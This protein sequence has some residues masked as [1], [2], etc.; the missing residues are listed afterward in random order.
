MESTR[1][2]I[3][4]DFAVAIAA[5]N[6]VNT[7]DAIEIPRQIARRRNHR[8]RIP[9]M[10]DRAQSSG[11]EWVSI[12]EGMYGYCSCNTNYSKQ[13]MTHPMWQS[14]F[15]AA[16]AQAAQPQEVPAEQRNAKQMLT[17]LGNVI[18]L[19]DAHQINIGETLEE[20][21]NAVFQAIIK[22]HKYWTAQPA[23]AAKPA[24]DGL[25]AQII[26]AANKVIVHNGTAA[27]TRSSIVKVFSKLIRTHQ[28]AR[29][30]EHE[31]A[32]PAEDGLEAQVR[33]VLQRDK[34]Y[35]AYS[36]AQLENTVAFIRARE[37]KLQEKLKGLLRDWDW[38][39]S[40]SPYGLD[41]NG[42]KIPM[43]GGTES[44]KELRALL[45]SHWPAQ[46]ERP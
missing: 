26:E 8:Q 37:R 6:G 25:E 32:K 45:A 21:D 4:W 39:E 46:K 10:R 38:G 36:D 31:A 27:L 12:G 34:F 17:N 5:N 15:V 42:N 16:S 29:E 14:H 19:L 20:D 7:T 2:S 23:S 33:E 41:E 3:N 22:R 40:N 9:K 24:E 35:R 43:R 30:R 28:A 11:H 13:V 44:A 1:E 18:A